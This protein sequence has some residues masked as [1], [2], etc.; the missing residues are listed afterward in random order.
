MHTNN[1]Q[2]KSMN[3]LSEN[4]IPFQRYSFLKKIFCQGTG[5]DDLNFINIKA[6]EIVFGQN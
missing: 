1:R 4:N 6:S 5:E 3:V 2:P